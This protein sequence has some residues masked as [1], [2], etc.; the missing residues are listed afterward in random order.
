M[1]KWEYCAIYY[2]EEE[3]FEYMSSNIYLKIDR[4]LKWVD[5]KKLNNY[6]GEI[7]KAFPTIDFSKLLL[8]Q[9][10]YFAFNKEKAIY[11]IL[12]YL[13]SIGWELFMMDNYQYRYFF[14][15]P[16]EGK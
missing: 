12:D 3:Y 6:E 10:E 7:I 16:I 4:P 15:R 11:V 9:N 14:K 8:R 1:Q 13:G 5:I 2:A